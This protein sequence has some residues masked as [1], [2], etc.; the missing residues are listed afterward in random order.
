[1]KAIK[2]NLYT[3]VK[4][5]LATAKTNAVKAV[6]FAMVIA[7]WQIGKRI[8][9]EEQG[10]SKRAA[11]G[12]K[13]LKDLSAQLTVDFG[14]GFSVQ[15][16]ENF[17]KFFILFPDNQKSY[18]VRR[19][20]EKENPNALI[21]LRI[22]LTWTHYRHLLRVENETARVYYMNEAAEQNWSTRTLERQINTLYFERLL[23]SKNKKPLIQ[24]AKKDSDLDKP[25][26]LDFIK[27]PYI[28]EFLE[29]QPNATLYE[30]DLE[31]ELLIN[32]SNFYWNLIKGFHL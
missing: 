31:T 4:S 16:L 9:E 25:T 21:G 29:L 10:G 5:I 17:R 12:E 27:D 1:M 2:R 30:K 6:N 28:L 13:V 18:A 8:V 15:N 7:Y 26:I 23:S 3:D 20:S 14:K 22:E 32:S 11:Y 19:I 24:K